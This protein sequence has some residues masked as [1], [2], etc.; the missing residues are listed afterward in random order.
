MVSLFTPALLLRLQV[1]LCIFNYV[2]LALSLMRQRSKSGKGGAA[3]E[4]GKAAGGKAA[5]GQ[6]SAA[7]PQLIRAMPAA[8]GSLRLRARA[9]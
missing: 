5:V 4:A 2:L 9:Q 3:G 1:V 8:D 7:Q 6:L